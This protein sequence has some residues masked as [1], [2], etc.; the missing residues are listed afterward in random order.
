MSQSPFAARNEDRALRAA[1]AHPR[2]V[3]VKIRRMKTKLRQ[4]RKLRLA[5]G[6]SI[7]AWLVV[8]A[9]S[10]RTMVVSRAADRSVRHTHEVLENLQDLLSA[11][12]SIES[13]DRGFVLTGQ[14]SYIE[15]H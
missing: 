7:L 8:G 5:I 9:V 15:T 4:N 3:Q 6:A 11:V 10:Y 14:E 13:S 12:E 2:T 1:I